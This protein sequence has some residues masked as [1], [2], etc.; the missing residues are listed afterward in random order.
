MPESPVQKRVAN[1]YWE[2]D[3]NS[4]I[5][6]IQWHMI[7]KDTDVEDPATVGPPRCHNGMLYLV[8]TT[9]VMKY[10]YE[11]A[12]SDTEEITCRFMDLVQLAHAAGGFSAPRDQNEVASAAL[13]M[14]YYKN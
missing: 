1:K 9:T 8:M 14:S 5:L 7:K 2:E 4:Y 13:E 11:D 12:S 10:M 3:E 6:Y